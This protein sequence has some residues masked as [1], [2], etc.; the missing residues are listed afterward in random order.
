MAC[1]IHGSGCLPPNAAKLF[2]SYDL[3]VA[4]VVGDPLFGACVM[5]CQVVSLAASWATAIHSYGA[6]E[7]AFEDFVSCVS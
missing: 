5:V 4:P 6:G 2:V 3:A 7:E 1:V